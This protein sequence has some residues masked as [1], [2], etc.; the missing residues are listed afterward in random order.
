MLIERN[1]KLMSEMSI[2]CQY[3][4]MQ[5]SP[6]RVIPKKDTPRHS[7]NVHIKFESIEVLITE[8]EKVKK[9]KTDVYNM[10]IIHNI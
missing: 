4:N 3:K 1:L 2:T 8:G 9:G 5:V 6:R 10:S 7:R